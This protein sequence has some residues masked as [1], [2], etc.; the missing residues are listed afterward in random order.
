MAWYADLADCNYFRTLHPSL[1]RAV[2]WLERGQA[3]PRG[4][5]DL[6]VFNKL[7]ELVRHAWQPCFFMGGHDCDLC[8]G[9]SKYGYTNLFIPGDGFLFVCPELIRHYIKDHQNAPPIEFCEAVLAC[10]PMNSTD[11][12]QVV[13]PLWRLAKT[14]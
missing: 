8:P 9:S 1:L 2:G 3:Y 14:P 4:T 11:Y 7:T 12:L 5:V 13:E 10:P 6:L